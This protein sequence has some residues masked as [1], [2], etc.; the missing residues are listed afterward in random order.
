MLDLEKPHL[1]PISSSVYYETN[2]ISSLTNH[3]QGQYSVPVGMYKSANDSVFHIHEGE[4]RQTIILVN[5]GPGEI[6]A[7][8]QLAT[9]CGILLQSATHGN[10]QYIRQSGQTADIYALF[11]SHEKAIVFPNEVGAHYPRYIRD[12]FQIIRECVEVNKSSVLG[13]MERLYD[14]GQVSANILR[15]NLMSGLRGIR[16]STRALTPYIDGMTGDSKR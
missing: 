4:K 14:T 10:D 1:C 13:E 7:E 8:H 15:Q 12:Q 6:I 9:D 16:V 2:H 5:P 11:A 3:P